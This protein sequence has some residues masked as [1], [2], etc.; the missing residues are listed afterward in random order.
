MKVFICYDEGK[1]KRF[2]SVIVFI[3]GVLGGVG[4]WG[5]QW[6]PSYSYI[7][8]MD[9]DVLTYNMSIDE[10]PHSVHFKNI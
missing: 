9:S 1:I 7:G 6:L 8:K 3:R 5:R 4:E 2:A 10:E